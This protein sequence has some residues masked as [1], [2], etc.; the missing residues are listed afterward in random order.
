M[1]LKL[2]AAGLI[3]IFLL[4][5]GLRPD[6]LPFAPGGAFSDAAVAHYPAADYLR[7]SIVDQGTLPLW[8]ELNMAGQPFAANPLNKTAYPLQWLALIFPP[9]WHL[10]ILIIL[11]MGIAALGM[12]RWTQA[13]AFRRQAV[14]IS[15]V[16]YALSP[17]IA[18]HT[19]AGHLDLLYAMAW[20][21]WLMWA[22]R[23]WFASSFSARKL[24]GL[25]L[26][27][28]LILLA[29]VRLSLFAYAIGIIYGIFEA[30]R[31]H[32]WSHAFKSIAAI[33]I[34]A[35]LILALIVPLLLWQ[36]YLSRTG[37]SVAEA[38]VFSLEPGQ[39][40]GLVLPQMHGNVETLTYTGISV[41]VLAML[42]LIAQ[43]AKHLEWLVM[44][45]LAI[46]YALGSN[47][48]VW[49]ALVEA[50][51]ILR[52]FRVPARAWLIIALTT[53]LLAGYGAN[54]LLTAAG[55]R[56]GQ[57]RLIGR[58]RLLTLIGLVIAVTC[59][60]FSW[61]S[62]PDLAE[63]GR[64]L[65]MIG[66]I[67]GV[68]IMLALSGRLTNSR[69]GVALMLAVAVDLTLVGHSW[70]EWRGED[71]WLTPYTQLAETLR[72]DNADRIYSPAYSL[73][74]QVAAAYDLH[75]FGG[76]DPFQLQGI[77][78]AIADGSGVR[79]QGY[80]VV[81]PP[82]TG[83]EG[84]DLR[85]VNRTAMPDTNVLGRWQ[86]SHVV[87][88]YPIDHPRLELLDIIQGTYVYHN[89]DYRLEID[90]ASVPRWAADQKGLPDTA[91]VM[92]INRATGLTM[93]TSGV[94]FAACLLI[95][96]LLTFKAR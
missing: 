4:V 21:P 66:G 22:I 73:P 75:L 45:G 80:S 70:L 69:L 79:A 33:P 7:H 9:T 84:D 19:G 55:D 23:D 54:W 83:I 49:R 56:R 3:G 71:E 96:G 92:E 37:L 88:P 50:L 74:Q 42:A 6:G 64:H 78:E 81:Q 13:L 85:G 89:L 34:W 65:L 94:A 46:V 17:R 91:T 43:P 29:D 8:W 62:L 57:P 2:L 31:D 35:M 61:V 39:L 63:S 18:A 16:A 12:A 11:H 26:I 41:L 10:N 67:T 68:I 53:P 44:G 60:L 58:T 51:P 82:L 30:A 1:R 38:G 27:A 15:A 95:Y 24:V 40:V 14:L 25:S 47:S 5:S 76:V 32:R 90:P 48:V 59:G 20:F 93:V 52:W 72:A 28:A 86:V 77:V 36:P 87:A